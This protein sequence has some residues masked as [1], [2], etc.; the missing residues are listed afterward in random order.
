MARRLLVLAVFLLAGVEKS[1]GCD[2]CGCSAMGSGVGLM[3]AFR[4]N[5]LGL[6]YHYTPFSSALEHAHG[7]RDYFHTME[8]V[9]RFHLATRF[10]G[11]LNQPYRLNVRR[12]PG[13]NQSLGGFGDTR[14]SLSYALLDQK[15]LG[16]KATLYVEAGLGVKAPT[17]AY[18]EN[19]LNKN[20]P[21]NFNTGL[22]AWGGI[23]QTNIGINL[24]NSGVALSGNYQSNW[25]PE[26]KYQFGDQWSGQA[27][28]FHQ[29][30][31]GA[32]LKV[33][34]FAG[35]AAEW[36]AQ[37]RQAD[38]K[39]APATGGSGVFAA[40]GCNLQV[41]NWLFGGSFLTPIKQQYS[42]DEVKAK[43]RFSLQFARIF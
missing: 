33:T 29:F 13:E 25:I 31:A 39:Y 8:T 24:K 2:A 18:D 27:Y 23:F 42:N 38:G 41:G 7:A 20:L 5:S 4:Q 34:H 12:H 37:D 26:G 11:Q 40:V 43:G 16:K 1:V 15:P 9:F 36:V 19:L 14:L 3:A 17:G 28:A 22:G 30:F 35:G 32:R 21:E 10:K 6:Q